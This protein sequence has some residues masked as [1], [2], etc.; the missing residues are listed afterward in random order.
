MEE[1]VGHVFGPRPL[2]ISAEGV[3]DFVEVTGDDLARWTETAPP[4][5][6]AAALFAVAPELLARLTDRFVVHGE[7]TFSWHRPLV[8][9]SVLEVT[10]TLTRARER[11]GSLFLGF[12]LE[13]SDD[14][15][16][17]LEG[18]SVFVVPGSGPRPAAE[19]RVEPHHTDRGSPAEGQVAASRADL[20]R[21][22]AATRDWNPIHW[23]HQAAVAAGFPGVVVHGLL[24]TAWVL[25]AAAQRASGSRPLAQARVRFRSPLLAAVPA[26]VTLTGEGSMFEGE[27]ASGPQTHLTARIEIADG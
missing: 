6:A 9:G 18:T 19:E 23:D 27:L 7:Q 3:A 15:G 8:V 16:P 21:Y 17:V 13:A 26:T 25:A 11:A 20:V 12:E 2:R 22:A 14:Q 24:Q 4:G 1:L 10:G 5:F